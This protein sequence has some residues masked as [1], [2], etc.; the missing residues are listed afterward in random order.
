GASLVNFLFADQTAH[1]DRVAVNGGNIGWLV[2]LGFYVTPDG[3][4]A[5]A[6]FDDTGKFTVFPD[7]DGDDMVVKITFAH[8]GANTPETPLPGA[9]WLF[10]GALAGGTAF[11]R[12]R[13]QRKTVSACAK[14]PRDSAGSVEL[15]LLSGGPALG[16]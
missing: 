12:L 6:F 10:G 14:H 7:F 11:A 8:S 9:L 16:A 15:P 1:P 4:T 3:Q 2:L 5:Y 13:K